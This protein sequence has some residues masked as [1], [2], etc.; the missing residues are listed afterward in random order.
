[1]IEKEVKDLLRDPRIYIGLI[2]PVI[3]LPLMGFA[4][5]AAMS[6]AVE[7]AT[8][9]LNVAVIDYDGTNTS[10]GLVSILVQVGLNASNI[11]A[12]SLE[13]ALE[14]AKNLNSKVLI[15]IPEGFEE[16]L[17]NF[18]KVRVDVYSI[19]ESV[20]FGSVG[21]QSVVD[22]AL[23]IS[24]EI[25][26]SMMI[27]RLAPDVEPDVV[28]EPLNITRYTVIRDRVMPISPQTI[29]GQLMMS[30][31]I[32]VPM[33]L[34]VLA[35]SVAQIAAIATAVE[36]E[37]KTLET[38]LTFP[39]TRYH[40]LMAKLIGS[41][42]VAV[43]GGIL[44]TVGFLIYFEGIF[45]MPGLEMGFVN[46]FQFLP[47]PPAG[48]YVV[49][50]L[51]LILSILFITSLGIVIG[52]LSS[53]VRMAGALLGVVIIPIMIPSILVMYGDLRALPIG[54]Q[55][56]IYALPTS[57]PM[58]MAKEMVLSGISVEAI[59]GIPYSAALTM[60][61]VYATSKL[62]APEKLLTLQY[63]LRIRRMRRRGVREET[64]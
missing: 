5:S 60:A 64:R 19:M 63:K 13:E 42:V 55:L 37:E 53:D 24:S 21:A 52:A 59:Y 28:R 56:F 15:V 20:G 50:A 57:Y 39:V 6:G 4:M 46:V 36:N 58:I 12:G 8:K 3:M 47:P 18:G 41:S 32:M 14:E 22:R 23:S 61:V 43:L 16:T 29:F 9:G 26:S 44:F 25:L 49:L 62:L 40:I 33:V 45:S 27:S 35:I 38:L 51:S 1:M 7:A 34:F 31:G 17:L 54:L 10:R 2:V 30:Y 11:E 48:A